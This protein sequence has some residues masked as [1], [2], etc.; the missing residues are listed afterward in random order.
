MELNEISE[1]EKAKYVS[2]IES[3]LKEEVG[4]ALISRKIQNKGLSHQSSK[5]L[6]QKVALERCETEKKTALFS[7]WGGL[8]GFII[9]GSLGY[10]STGRR[11]LYLY[12][13]GAF[14]GGLYMYLRS[15]K[16]AK[17]LKSIFEKL[18]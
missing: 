9:L 5:E 7:F 14:A 15:T 3:S 17:Y 10:Q 16:R 8:A 12:A 13:F 4:L 2:I 1:S 18:S 11:N 6:I